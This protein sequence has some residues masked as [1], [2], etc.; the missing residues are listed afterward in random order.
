MFWKVSCCTGIRKHLYLGNG[1]HIMWVCVSAGKGLGNL[2]FGTA[3]E[4]PGLVRTGTFIRTTIIPGVSLGV[5]GTLVYTHIWKVGS[6]N[7]FTYIDA[8]WSLYSRQLLKTLTKGIIAQIEQFLLLPVFSS[9]FN[10][11]T[12]IYRDFS[13]FC[14]DVFKVIWCRFAV[15]GKGLISLHNKC[16]FKL[17]TNEPM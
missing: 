7:Q 6:I 16:I 9:L 11:Y 14:L 5:D 15:C 10:Y 1:L 13:H 3:V 8:F 4:S 2:P 12:I 17:M